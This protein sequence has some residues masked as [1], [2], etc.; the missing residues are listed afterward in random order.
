[1]TKYILIV[2]NGRRVRFAG[3]ERLH[4]RVEDAALWSKTDARYL[5]AI[6]AQYDAFALAW[7][8]A[9]Q[10]ALVTPRASVS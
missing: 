3:R 4:M 10:D 5:C 7:P 1:M 8:V 2:V 6:I 9:G